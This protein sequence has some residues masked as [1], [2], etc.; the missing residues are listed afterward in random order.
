MH[1]SRRSV[2][3]S[4]SLSPNCSESLRLR[5]DPSD[6]VRGLSLDR[7]GLHP[8]GAELCPFETLPLDWKREG[9]DA[10]MCRKKKFVALGDLRENGVIK[11]TG[12]SNFCETHLQELKNIGTPIVRNQIEYIPFSPVYTKET[13]LEHFNKHKITS[14]GGDIVDNEKAMWN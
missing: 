11:N 2:E 7:A 1:G 10:A 9:K 12:V 5:R 4:A 13:L 14:L 3:R 8:T 6:N